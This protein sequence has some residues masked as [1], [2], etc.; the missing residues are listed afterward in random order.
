[1]AERSEMA[2]RTY[3]QWWQSTE[4]MVEAPLEDVRRLG[5][6]ALRRAGASED[7]A[8]F[9]F[10]TALD[11]ALQGDHAR[12]LDSVPA[13]VRAAIQG[14]VDL[15]GSVRVLRETPAM[16]LVEGEPKAHRTLVCRTA[17]ETAI[18]RAREY[19]IGWVSLRNPVG[20]LTPHVVQAVEAGMVGMVMTQSFPTVAPTGGYRPLLGNAP[21]A[22]GIPTGERD[23]V[24]LDMSLTQTSAAG[25]LLAALQGV[26]A[27]EGFILDEHG[28]PT[29]DASAFP[30]TGHLT[31]ES[32]RAA[33]TLLPLGGNHKGYALVFVVGLLTAVLADANAP[34]EAGEITGGRPAHEPFRYGSLFMALDPSPFVPLDELHRRVDAF[35]DHVKAEPTRP[36]FAEILYPG[37][38]SQRLK[39]Q[40]RREGVFLLPASHYDALATL[41]EEL[42][43]EETLPPRR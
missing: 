4:E 2:Q 24:I 5:L 33:G 17:M 27:P 26:P 20:I 40:R 9:I 7:D 31:R 3:G 36:G 34:W 39:R 6:A 35:I 25:V 19:G 28:N 12:G 43:L 30:A 29:T 11:K 32:Q 14:A 42:G 10:D 37:E 1:M 38:M 21:V 16:A 41:S 22:F 13:T 23:P 8:A 18:R 15:H